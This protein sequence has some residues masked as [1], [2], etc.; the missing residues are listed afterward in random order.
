[1][2]A[3]GCFRAD[4]HSDNFAMHYNSAFAAIWSSTLKRRFSRKRKTI[5]SVGHSARKPS[6]NYSEHDEHEI[7]P[8]RLRN[9]RKS[10]SSLSIENLSTETMAAAV[11]GKC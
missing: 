2:M 3:A 7:K 10:P 5:K 6:N 9:F 1:M 4:P 8:H 11:K